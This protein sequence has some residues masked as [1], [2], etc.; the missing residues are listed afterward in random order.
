MDDEYLLK[1]LVNALDVLSLFETEVS[2]TPKEVESKINLNRT[3][4]YRILYTLRHKGLLELDPQTGEYKIGMKMFHLGSLS[5][6]RLDIK[7]IS[8]PHLLALRD[9]VNESVHLVIKNNDAVTF[10]DKKPAKE[11]IF[12]GSYVGWNAPLYCTA[13][14][15]ILLSFETNEYINNYFKKAPRKKYT[16][17]T[18]ESY[19]KLIQNIEGIRQLGY[20][21]DQEEMVEGLTC[22]A[23][24]I[25]GHDEKV[26]ASISVSGSTTKMTEK[27]G[28]VIE[29][30]FKV[31]AAISK[32]IGKTPDGAIRS[33][34]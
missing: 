10:I 33:F 5:L 34:M 23:V 8:H 21:T 22:Y 1:T 14:G 27:K 26:I 15:K 13:S 16:D 20:S 17:H 29:E 30:L 31:T 19:E 18:L 6:Q 4:I 2:L 3:S 24:P 11:D 28:I 7:N 9:T 25:I 32:A 12:M